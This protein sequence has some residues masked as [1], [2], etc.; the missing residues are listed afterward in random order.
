MFFLSANNKS[1][2]EDTQMTFTRYQPKK[3]QFAQ[4]PPMKKPTITAT[5]I[6]RVTHQLVGSGSLKNAMG[7]GASSAPETNA[8]SRHSEDLTYWPEQEGENEMDQANLTKGWNFPEMGWKFKVKRG[9][10]AVQWNNLVV[11][12]VWG[13]KSYPVMWG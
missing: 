7:C 1:N 11:H 8:G 3:K 4:L 12:G 2:M 6:C 9:E 10:I 5:E 13:M